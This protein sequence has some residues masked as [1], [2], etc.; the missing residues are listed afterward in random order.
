M[1]R[2][3]ALACVAAAASSPALAQPL[4][5][6]DRGVFADL[7]HAV[8][9]APITVRPTTRAVVDTAHALI[10]VLDGDHP[11]SAFP[12]A[13]K[14]VPFTLGGLAV[15]VR[16]ADVPRLTPLAK[17]PARALVPGELPDG[18]DDG[19][20]DPLDVLIGAKKVAANGAEYIEGYIDIPFPNG[21]V[22]RQ[23]GVCT[24]VVVR[25]LRN[26]G[27]DLQAEL[28]TDI[29][30]APRSY[31][32]VKKRNGDIDH[33]RVRTI[34]PFFARH[35]RAH[36]TDPKDA[37]DPFQP[38]DVIFM[39]T[40]PN[41]SGPDHIGI[42]SDTRGP[43]GMLLVVN[44]WTVGYRESEMDLLPFVPVTAR[45]RLSDRSPAARGAGRTA[46]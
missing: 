30:R 18:D 26:A 6:A 21:D 2:A 16:A 28:H 19:I 36:A 29:G 37:A 9:L 34:A 40:M 20:P 25:A 32:M 31:P 11:I 33:R 13:T 7:D 41:R 3:L 8:T 45:Y 44:N 5:L 15:T 22:P 1:V 14:G 24:D 43:N 35:F 27:F 39:D 42:V 23:M 10:V 38:G 12:L 17:I 46:R 4:G